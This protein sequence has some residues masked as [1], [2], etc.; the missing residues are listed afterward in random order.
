MKNLLESEFNVFFWYATFFIVKVL[1][2]NILGELSGCVC[3][4]SRVLSFC[5]MSINRLPNFLQHIPKFFDMDLELS[6]L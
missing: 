6:Y 4:V 5:F 3:K 1:N 2:I